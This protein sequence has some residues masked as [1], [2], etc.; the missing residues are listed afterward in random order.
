MT[1]TRGITTSIPPLLDFYLALRLKLTHWSKGVYIAGLIFFGVV[2]TSLLGIS[3]P[4]PVA[5]LVGWSPDRKNKICLCGPRL[6]VLPSPGPR[7]ERFWVYESE[8]WANKA[9]DWA[10]Y[11]F[12]AP[13][14]IRSI[15]FLITSTGKMK[16][17]VWSEGTHFSLLSAHVNI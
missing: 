14:L 4:I 10:F 9:F 12:S 1:P 7:R 2:S 17:S 13:H 15:T 3:L 6:C 5:R 16:S 11:L 8:C